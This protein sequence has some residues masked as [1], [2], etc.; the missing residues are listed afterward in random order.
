MDTGGVGSL[1]EVGDGGTDDDH[2]LAVG[3]IPR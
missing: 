1:D 3:A 2:L